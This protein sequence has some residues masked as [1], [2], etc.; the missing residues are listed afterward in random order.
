MTTQLVAPNPTRQPRTEFFYPITESAASALWPDHNAGWG[1]YVKLVGLVTVEVQDPD[2]TEKRVGI[3]LGGAQLTDT[4]LAVRLGCD[5]VKLRYDKGVLFKVGLL[6]QRRY[7]STY[8]LAIR[9]SAKKGGVSKL[10]PKYSWVR[11]AISKAQKLP[12]NRVEHDSHDVELDTEN[13]VERDSCVVQPDSCDV[14]PDSLCHLDQQNQRD[15]LGDK[16]EEKKEEEREKPT[17]KSALSTSLESNPTLDEV[18]AKLTS[19]FYAI[20][21]AIS[22]NQPTFSEKHR[23]GIKDLLAT[24]T[25]AE[26]GEAYPEFV[27]NLDD[28]QM[29]NAP[30]HFVE[31]ASDIINSIRER[32]RK[33]AVLIEQAQRQREATETVPRIR[34]VEEDLLTEQESKEI[35]TPQQQAEVSRRRVLLGH[36]KSSNSNNWTPLSASRNMAQDFLDCLDE[37]NDHVATTPDFQ[38]EMEKRLEARDILHY[39]STLAERRE[40]YRLRCGR[41]SAVAGS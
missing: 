11:E 14:Q 4:E 3:I 32:K 36:F 35:L 40:K 18:C 16:K 17:P 2:D 1:L 37:I 38:T 20:G 10:D 19:R 8:R 24:Y 28:F 33:E 41:M 21:Q 9:C 26:L 7:R 27:K 30:K 23:A 39:Q 12:K 13:R 6:L 34:Q 15:G 22:P 31:G 5:P 29:K 25:E